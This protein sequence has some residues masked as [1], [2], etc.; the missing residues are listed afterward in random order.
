MEGLKRSN[1]YDASGGGGTRR[2]CY[3]ALLAIPTSVVLLGLLI[4]FVFGEPTSEGASSGPSLAL[5][6]LPAAPAEGDSPAESDTPAATLPVGQPVEAAPDPAAAPSAVPQP[7]ESSAAAA[8]SP[9]ATAAPGGEGVRVNAPPQEV[10]TGIILMDLAGVGGLGFAGGP[11]S[12]E[13]QRAYFDAAIAEVNARG[14]GG[15]RK[16]VPAYVT[17]DP[18]SE[19]SM[20]AACL[21]L[22]QDERVFAALNVGGYYGDSVL[23][24]TERFKVGFVAGTS[25]ANPWY[26]RSGG[27]FFSVH[28]SK[29]RQLANHAG[30]LDRLGVLKGAR[31]GI[32]TKEPRHQDGAA[33]VRSLESTLRSLGHT[34]TYRSELSNDAGTASTQMPVV[35]S[36][37]RR[38]GVDLVFIATN[39]VYATQFVQQA[40]S[41]GF[42]PRYTAS[43]FA[44]GT[45]DFSAQNMPRSFDGAIG[46]TSTRINEHRA[47]RPEPQRDRACA[48]MIRRRSGIGLQRGSDIYGA[49][50][51]ACDL[52]EHY[53]AGLSRAAGELTTASWSTGMQALGPIDL[54]NSGRGSFAPGKYDAADEVRTVQWKIDCK[55]WMPAGEFVRGRF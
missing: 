23:C 4:P 35:V 30:E 24:L 11:G 43:D 10:R 8:S 49:A 3:L 13:E 26:Q 19:S 5:E 46:I 29:D 38:A 6:E 31:I 53:A 1:V 32:L 9:A 25:E 14:V 17:F 51:A 52:V 18:L 33:V 16:I 50:I 27:R 28:A 21:R 41:Q 45:V 34:V 40:D 48:E 55:C 39:A 47:G 36:E 44:Q 7:T 22:A 42:R 15:A 20:Q 37:M 54:S 12:V 2:R